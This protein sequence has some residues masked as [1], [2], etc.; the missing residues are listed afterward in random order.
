MMNTLWKTLLS[1]LGFGK[2]EKE[3]V[4]DVRLDEEMKSPFQSPG[5][6]RKIVKEEKRI[7]AI[8]KQSGQEKCSVCL[9]VLDTSCYI[10]R[11]CGHI[12]HRQCI[13]QWLEEEA[14]CPV[15]KKF[16]S[17]DLGLICITNDLDFLLELS[18]PERKLCVQRQC[19]VCDFSLNDD[20]CYILRRCGHIVHIDCL[21]TWS[22][23]HRNCPVCGSRISQQFGGICIPENLNRYLEYGEEKRLT[24]L[25]G[26]YA[27]K[28][29]W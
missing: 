17:E 8:D 13:S 10:L 26:R 15:C 12:F 29:L 23:T 16:T 11:N 20:S 2:G 14:S 1:C 21:N 18:V 6:S 28:G 7:Y 19:P 22:I 25:K 9:D 3:D 5:V 4:G 27:A 24:V